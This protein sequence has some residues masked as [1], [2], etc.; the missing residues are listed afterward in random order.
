MNIRIA[1]ITLFF[2]LFLGATTAHAQGASVNGVIRLEPYPET[3]DGGFSYKYEEYVV[4]YSFATMDDAKNAVKSL[5]DSPNDTPDFV[6][7]YVS[8]ETFVDEG[9]FKISVPDGGVIVVWTTDPTF[10]YEKNLN[11]NGEYKHISA[12]RTTNKGGTC[13]TLFFL[14]AGCE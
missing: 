9:S 4:V 2:A 12:Q 3:G 13:S 10:A 11:K 7:D 5:K 6:R 1:V 8:P 14:C